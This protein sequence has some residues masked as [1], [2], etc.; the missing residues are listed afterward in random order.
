MLAPK[1]AA[2]KAAVDE[3]AMRKFRTS[4]K[5]HQASGGSY[6]KHRA[7]FNTGRKPRG[8]VQRCAAISIRYAKIKSPYRVPTIDIQGPPEPEDAKA[9][10][11]YK[12][13]QFFFEDEVPCCT[14][15]VLST[16]HS[17]SNPCPNATAGGRATSRRGPEGGARQQGS[18][19]APEAGPGGQGL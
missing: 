16:R 19:P 14:H 9:T 7:T 1:A 18:G 2:Q 13:A 8:N 10:P 11:W 17:H 5:A 4:L 15:A 12:P 3:L 6:V